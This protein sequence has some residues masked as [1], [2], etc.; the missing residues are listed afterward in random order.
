MIRKTFLLFA[1]LLG[2]SLSALA[3]QN[4][5]AVIVGIADY[6]NFEPGKGDLNYTVS[7]AQRFCEFLKSKKGGSVPESNIVMLTNGQ[8]TKANI[9]EQAKALFAKAQKNDR[10]I[11]YFSG[12]GSKGCFLPYEAGDIGNN[13]LYFYEIKSIFRKANCNTKLLFADA[14]FAGS[15]MNTV[16]GAAIKE[17]VDKGIVEKRTK[18]PDK[19][20]IAVIMSCEGGQSS[21]EVINL[22]QGL[23]TFYL[24]KGLEGEANLDDNKFITIYELF[25]Y[26]H[27]KVAAEAKK[28]GKQ[29]TP[30]TFGHYDLRLIVAE[31]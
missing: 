10:V 22:K 19:M 16:K 13:L 29:Q 14:C 15:M 6:K 28:I 9:V 21:Q 8:A 1:L 18:D 11:F 17:S 30:I 2:T 23:F 7:D 3:Y 31:L 20:D 5:Y 12:H 25:K 26:V 24:I 27:D 4:T